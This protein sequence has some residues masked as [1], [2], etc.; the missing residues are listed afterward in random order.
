MK[1]AFGFSALVFAP[2]LIAFLLPALFLLPTGILL[3][4]ITIFDLTM[5]ISEGA[6]YNAWV[7]SPMVAAVGL[8][9]AG[10]WLH[11]FYLRGRSGMTVWVVIWVVFSVALF[12]AAWYGTTI[13]TSIGASD[14]PA[15]QFLQ[16]TAKA[17]AFLTFAFQPGVVLWLFVS[18]RILRNLESAAILALNSPSKPR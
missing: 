9:L 17:A 2:L 12:L 11:S 3:T 15:I 7:C 8:L 18:S 16:L 13:L 6:G 4:V 14:Y 10:I 5:A 1:T